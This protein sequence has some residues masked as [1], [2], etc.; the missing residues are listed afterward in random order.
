VSGINVLDCS[1][2]AKWPNT[3][4]RFPSRECPVV[5][6]LDVTN[7]VSVSVSPTEEHDMAEPS[8]ISRR[9]N[10]QERRYRR[11]S[12]RY[13][14]N[15]KFHSENSVSELR[16][17][18]RNISLGGVLLEADSALPQHCD[19][20]FIVTV[21]GHHII[22]PTQILGEGEVVRVEPQRS[23]AGFAIAVKCKRPISEL[24]G[25]LPAFVGNTEPPETRH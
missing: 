13:P 12:L 1:D 4:Y 16:A 11:F 21:R 15:I 20:S 24:Q 23:G 10:P 5:H 25:F 8:H 22:G 17:I 6:L 18:S 2:V 9:P 14:V 19:V 7:S 3:T